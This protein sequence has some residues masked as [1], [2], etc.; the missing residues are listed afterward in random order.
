[1]C[2]VR[3]YNFVASTRL[4]KEGEEKIRDRL[5]ETEIEIY[6]DRENGREEDLENHFGLLSIL[7][8]KL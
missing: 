4:A 7:T 3:K 2:H 6:L 1:M 8:S 5:G